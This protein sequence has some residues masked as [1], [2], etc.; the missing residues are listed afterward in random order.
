MT[1]ALLVVAGIVAAATIDRWLFVALDPGPFDPQAT[2]PAPDYDAPASWAALPELEDGAD[3]A[4]PEHPAIDQTAAALDVFYLH[5][6]T[7]I[8]TR[9]NAPIDEPA[10]IEATTRGGTLIQASVFNGVGAI[11]APRYRQAHGRAFTQPDADGDR[12]IAVALADVHAA[13]DAFLARTG[14][15][16][17]VLA[18]HSQGSVLGGRLLAERIAGTELAQRLVVAYL[19]GAP[20]RAEALGV[21][22]CERP[23]QTGC[24][25]VWN[26]RGPDYEPNALEFGGADRSA[27]REWIC[28]NP[29]SGIHDEEHVPAER[30]RGAV[31]LDTEH[32]R[33]LPG[34]ADGRCHE[35]RLIV[36]TMGELERDPMSRIL[37]WVIGP[38]NYHPIEY[39]LHYLDLRHDVGERVAAFLA[40]AS[41]PG[42]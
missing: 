1:L 41:P 8:G 16:P 17:F 28:V 2:P 31:F 25:V 4:L 19:P 21:P 42:S 36:E 34:F 11:H 18:G 9:W 37:L 14:G 10:I 12:A 20:L 15:R 27:M 35:G 40:A 29:I 6:T 7:A 24:A 23:A 33:V 39:Q 13:F 30:S 38:E 3:L 22:V 26:A 32:P 5:P